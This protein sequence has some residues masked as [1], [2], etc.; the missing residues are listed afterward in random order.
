MLPIEEQRL[1]ED[2]L[3]NAELLTEEEEDSILSVEEIRRSVLSEFNR[4]A[5]LIDEGLSRGR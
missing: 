1:K 2:A 4:K 3:R 5:D